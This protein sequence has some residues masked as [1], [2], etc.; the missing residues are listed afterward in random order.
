M[1]GTWWIRADRADD[2]AAV[3]RAAAALRSSH[4]WRVL[5]DM[6]DEGDYPKVLW[7][8]ADKVADGDVPDEYEAGLGC[9]Q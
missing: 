1:D 2:E 3:K 5:H 9:D 7:A 6:N 8:T 4:H